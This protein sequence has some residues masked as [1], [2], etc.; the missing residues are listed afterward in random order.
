MPS[1]MKGAAAMAN[2]SER[3][4]RDND[5]ESEPGVLRRLT[6]EIG[7]TT[8]E[9][10][11]EAQP[12]PQGSRRSDECIREDICEALIREMRVDVSEV[13]VEVRDGHVT[14]DGAV[15][16]RRMRYIIEDVAA[17]CSGVNDVENRVRVAR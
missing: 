15:P 3:T 1:W 17:A 14:L 10:H 6:D 13:T 11:S 5:G 2:E 9:A 12:A 7:L 4:M 8:P 16:V